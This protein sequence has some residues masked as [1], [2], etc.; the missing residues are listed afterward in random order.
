MP[1]HIHA[2]TASVGIPHLVDFMAHRSHTA[3]AQ[4]ADPDG[5]FPSG[6]H[7]ASASGASAGARSSGRPVV[8]KV[9]CVARWRR[10]MCERPVAVYLDA[11]VPNAHS[12][13]SN[14]RSREDTARVEYDRSAF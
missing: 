7:T 10:I 11:L 14:Q 1:A 13:E 5:R 9:G 12:T 2:G 8:S 6:T 4:T 3:G